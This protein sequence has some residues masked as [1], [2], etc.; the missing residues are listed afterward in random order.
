MLRLFAACLMAA[1]LFAPSAHA[2]ERTFRPLLYVQGAETP[3]RLQSAS[4]DVDIGGGMADTTV[5]LVFHNPNRRV[6][7]GELRFPLAP[8]QKILGFALD[9]GGEMRPAV[10]V[11]K[12]RGRQVF[13]EIVRRGVDPGLLETTQG[14]NFKLRI[15]PIPPGGER[16][17][18]L[19]IVQAL[20]RSGAEWGYRF[21]VPWAA[22]SGTWRAAARID[23]L[24]AGAPALLDGVLALQGKLETAPRAW[25]GDFEDASYAVAEIPVDAPVKPRTLPRTVGLLWD[26]SGSGATRRHDLEFALLDRYFRAA[27][28]TEVRL[29]RLRDRA[30]APRSF[31]VRG[32]DWSALRRELEATVYDGA[33][34][35]GGWT[36]DAGVGEYL[37]F[38][39][40]LENYGAR[41]FPLLARGQRLFAVNAASGGADSARL[42]ALAQRHGGRAIDLAGGL[43][44]SAAALLGDGVRIA[45][46]SGE[47]LA[48]LQAEAI[49]ARGGL[50]RVAGR[51]LQPEATLRVTLSDGRTIAVTVDA[52]TPRQPLAPWLWAVWRIDALQADYELKRSEI[53]RLGK[54]F[55][56]PT[57]DTSLIVLERLDD[58]VRYDIPAP[59]G[60]RAAVA[61]RKGVVRPGEASAA[62]LE[63]VVREL[64]E[65]LAWWQGSFPAKRPYY[66][67]NGKIFEEG[68]VLPPPPPMPVP[69]APPAPSAPPSPAPFAQPPGNTVANATSALAPGEPLRRSAAAPAASVPLPT[70]SIG[71]A[72][73]KWTPDQRYLDRMARADAH[74]AYAIYLDQKPDY[75]AS[76]AFY[77]DV[78]DTLLAKGDRM[79]ALR[80]L[81]N[82]AEMD[83][84]NRHVLRV[85]GYRL[86]QAGAPELAVPVFESVLRLAE[87]EP[88]SWRDLGLAYAAAGRPQQ[89]VDTL[90]QV[91]V[92]DWNGRFSEIELITLADLNAIVAAKRG[93]LDTSRF[94]SR[95]LRHMPLDLR[96]V[97]SWD[98]DNSDMDLWVTD[99]DGERCMFSNRFTRLGGRLSRDNTGGYGPEEFSLRRAKPG[100]YKVEANFYGQRQQIV[101][102]ATTLQ[103][104]LATGFG[105]ARVKERM[106]TLRLRGQGDSVLVGEFEVP[107]GR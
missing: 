102:G 82:L 56:I 100:K 60:L 94:D 6:L 24:D 25:I 18:R 107:A 36:P 46:L 13:E 62:K 106:V 65:K 76:T 4:L 64:E 50:L 92:R 8:G 68:S 3:V 54:R 79:L 77:L 45:A 59:P 58:Y 93:K 16:R 39:D 52:N 21:P 86:L 9:I 49:D 17:V 99:P 15:Y 32:G 41:G 80:V 67:T 91:A 31:R 89:A 10:A 23:G 84:E 38:S 37:L 51:R 19:R 74:Q 48:E 90:Y 20:A 105:T 11:D 69:P 95:L 71:I 78:A 55:G 57:R 87:E 104:K 75:A 29:L 61:Q 81:S 35:L 63:T 5:D 34:A 103:L 33:T 44:A 14:D 88:Q 1:C 66:D 28:D 53:G 70:P 7:E 30:E 2:Q 22:A 42:D 27:G 47:G 98:S 101:T 72:L 96:V 83:L 97:L 12:A 26:S 73:R 43:D 85:L 40:G